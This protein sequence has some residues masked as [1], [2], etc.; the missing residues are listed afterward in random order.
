MVNSTTTAEVICLDFEENI[1]YIGQIISKE[2]LTLDIDA[3]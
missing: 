2:I 1:I 3:L